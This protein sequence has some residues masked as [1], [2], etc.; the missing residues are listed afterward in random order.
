MDSMDVHLTCIDCKGELEPENEKVSCTECGKEY[1]IENGIYNLS[2]SGHYYSDLDRKRMRDIIQKAKEMGWRN[3][4]SEQFTQNRFLCRI[5]S[6]ETRADWQYLLPLN[7]DHIALD[8]GAGWGTISIPLARNLKHV[9]ALDGTDDRLEFLKVRAE[10]DGINNITIVHANLFDMPFQEKQFDLVSFNGVLEWVGVDGDNS[11]NP[12]EKQIE[13]LNVA[14]KVLKDDGYLYIGIENS[15][16][17]KYVLGEPD[18]HTGIPYI[19]YL[20]RIDANKISQAKQGSDYRTYT[21]TKRGY[22]ELLLTAGFT[23]VQFYYPIPDYKRIES[24]HNLDNNQISRFVN[25]TIQFSKNRR[26]ISERVV[27]ME[28]L[29]IETGSLSHFSASYSIVARKAG[30]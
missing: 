6:D 21:Y 18:D 9:V 7:K 30:A 1:A 2:R 17:L 24:L 5:I 23:D 19:T 27:D 12:T 20:D 3:A 28:K 14:R 22:E 16:G 13:A 10:Q 11:S 8:I 25:E 15:Y 29:L 26:E 4:I